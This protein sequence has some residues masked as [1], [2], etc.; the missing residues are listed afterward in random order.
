M[1]Q[2][3]EKKQPRPRGTKQGRVIKEAAL[4]LASA[5]LGYLRHPDTLPATQLKAV[6]LF[7]EIKNAEMK[8]ALQAATPAML[9][10]SCGYQLRQ[11]H[12]GALAGIDLYPGDVIALASLTPP[13]QGDLIVGR[14][15][16]TDNSLVGYYYQVGAGQVFLLGAADKFHCWH[17]PE[18]EV[19]II[20]KV[21]GFDAFYDVDD[22][23]VE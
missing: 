12:D 16:S 23:E 1:K 2:P 11:L 18:A 10:E 4:D 21:V 19:E 7:G 14:R 9:Q 13:E 8:Q 5:L 22:L 15:K 3:L 6:A 17:L 20:G